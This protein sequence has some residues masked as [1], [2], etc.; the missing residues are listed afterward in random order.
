MVLPRQNLKLFTYPKSK[1]AHGGSLS[2]GRRKS[3]RP[4]SLKESI[5]VVL[6]AERAKGRYSLLLPKNAKLVLKLMKKYGKEFQVKV[7][8]FAFVSNHM[9]LTL[10]AKTRLGFQ[11]F[12]R[13]FAGQTAQKITGAMKG[14]PGTKR[15]WDLL[16]FSRII[17]WGRAY[18]I[19]IKYI[20]KNVK[21]AASLQKVSWLLNTS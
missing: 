4:L 1:S 9:H 7:Y 20:D 10:K 19:V 11:N 15:F 3:R 14:N 12:L 8:H 16:A 18:K 5:H 2:V 21:Q 6:R 13:V 17:T